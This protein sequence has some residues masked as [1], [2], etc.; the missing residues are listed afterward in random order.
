[1]KRLLAI[2]LSVVL[3]LGLMSACKKAPSAGD[4][5]T[6][7]KPA[8]AAS[9][10]VIELNVNLSFSEKSGQAVKEAC[11]RIEAASGGRVKFSLYYS[12]SLVSVPDAIKSLQGGI[13]DIIIAPAQEYPS[14]FIR[15]GSLMAL[16][17][18]Q[19]P[20]MIESTE[21]FMD[22]Y[23]QNESMRQEIE[24]NGMKLWTVSYT[25]PQNIHSTGSQP[26]VDPADLKGHKIIAA[27]TELQDLII[28][29]GG[30][31]ISATGPEYYSTLEKGVADSVVQHLNALGA[32]GVAPELINSST[33]FGESGL[34]MTS[35][36]YLIN[37]DV[38]NTLPED[39]QALFEAEADTL[40]INQ[41]NNDKAMHD[42]V[43]AA[44][45]EK[46]IPMTELTEA[47][48]QVWADAFNDIRISKLQQ[49]K[50]L[51]AD[52]IEELYA[53]LMEKIAQY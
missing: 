21:I 27:T 23:N 36:L 2:V 1:M 44:L 13:V 35:V 7:D 34:Y 41:T 52:D 53:V 14:F 48:I 4:P 15:T 51:G 6:V 30:A 16:P 8:A 5:A 10:D 50:G 3:S 33:I 9:G 12:W 11:D 26:I 42:S 29:N 45:K 28:A 22:L 18:I 20:G 46:G 43:T 19:L 38:W 17:M 40:R 39:I 37:L 47:Q 24:G 32:F 49:M 31:P 25:A